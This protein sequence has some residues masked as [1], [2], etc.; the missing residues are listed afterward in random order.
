[1]E[2]N[3]ASGHVELT[4]EELSQLK[5][6]IEASEVGGDRYPEGFA[7]NLYADTPALEG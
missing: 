6:A 2:E 7:Q 1:M 3:F 5:T 4:S